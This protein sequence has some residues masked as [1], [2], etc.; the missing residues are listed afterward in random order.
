MVL[1]GA[2]IE[3]ASI[4]NIFGNSVFAVVFK[5]VLFKVSLIPASSLALAPFFPA[6]TIVNST[7]ATIALISDLIFS[8]I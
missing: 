1:F 6:H 3:L 2:L 7:N 4:S 8:F 5:N